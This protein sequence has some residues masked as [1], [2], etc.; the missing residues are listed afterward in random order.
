VNLHTKFRI[1][2]AVASA[3]LFT[4]SAFWLTSE[5]SRLMSSKEEQASNLV[6]SAYSIMEQQYRL[7]ESGE[8]SRVEAQKRTA[9]I[10]SSMRY[11]SGN[12]FW[13]NDMHPRMVVHPMQSKLNGADLSTYVDASGKAFF[14][15]MVEIAKRDGQG[16]V[17]Y[18]WPRPGSQDQTAISKLSFVKRFEP[19]GWIVGTGVYIDDVEKAWLSSAK[20]AAGLGFAC[21]AVLLCVSISISHSI[22]RKLRSL[23]AWMKAITGKRGDFSEVQ[24]PQLDAKS[25]ARPDEVDVLVHGFREMLTEIR[26]RDG[27]LRQHEEELEQLVAARTAQLKTASSAIA[28]AHAELELFLQSIPSILIG[29]DAEGRVKR[30]NSTAAQTFGIS[31]QDA[32]GR[33]LTNCGIEW[34]HPNI[35][36][37]ISSWL[38]ANSVLRCE[39]IAYKREA[40]V[41][42]VGFSVR[43]IFSTSNNKL[44]F[45]VTGADVTERKCLEEQ[46]RQAQK[47]EAIG[48]LAAGI[49]HEINTPT[50]FVGDNTTFV[51]KSW[52]PIISLLDFCRNMHEEAA[53]TGS[54]S[55]QSLAAFDRLSEECDLPYL[56][57]EIPHAIDQS[58]EGLQRVAKIVRAMKEFSYRGAD[59]MEPVDLNRAI[60]ATI[61]VAKGEWKHVADVVTDLAPEIPTVFG[62]SGELKQV[63]LNLIVNAAHAIADVANKDAGKKGQI[64]ITTRL[65]GDAVEVSIKDTGAGISDDVRSRIFEPFFTTKP[66]GKGTGQGL[67]LAH[68]IVVNRH[69]GKIWF[70][71]RFGEGTTFFVRL[72]I[73]AKAAQAGA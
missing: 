44:G 31:G 63:F 5:R 61:T 48:Q 29:L 68:S 21:L 2:V 42:F 49:A 50:Q 8:L 41:H 60:E 6:N 20:T 17:R 25:P 28:M 51:K 38:A 14:V 47:L 70:H 67:A 62:M 9:N 53:K 64:T 12:Y 65:D 72:P 40:T 30:W 66:L 19:W 13:I 36:Q 73:R 54:V 23:V 52:E 33:T 71:T 4:L 27:R 46:L 7:E 3:G 35:D 32:L 58:L 15:E 34:L 56:R 39:H 16:F 18:Q 1:T 26:R 37:E 59:E 24:E 11:D 55:L 45:I 57:E 69:Q 22:F 43:P 10:I